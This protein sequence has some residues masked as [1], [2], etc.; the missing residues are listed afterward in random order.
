MTKKRDQPGKWNTPSIKATVSQPAD[1]ASPGGEQQQMVIPPE[2]RSFFSFVRVK[3]SNIMQF[4][5]KSSED[6]AIFQFCKLK[7]MGYRGKD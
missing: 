3:N 6:D 5:Q 2:I 4:R 7:S 1:S